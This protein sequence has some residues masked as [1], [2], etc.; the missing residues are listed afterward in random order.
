[1]FLVRQLHTRLCRIAQERPADVVIGGRDNPYLLRWWLVPRN[2]LVNVYLHLFLRSDDDRALHDHPWA[3]VSVLLDGA[4]TEHTIAAGGV[5]CRRVYD[6]GAVRCRRATFAH[7]I[8]LHR[9][10]CWTLFVTGPKV[11]D[12]FFHC[13]EQGR[14][15]WR[16]FVS[17]VDEGG[18]GA[19]CD[20]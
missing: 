20:G 10:E 5:H 13:P 4:Y 14:V 2:R 8:E 1:M 17:P 16:R 6:V 15:P 3:S 18:V 9:G 12:W 7:R 19:G 11:R